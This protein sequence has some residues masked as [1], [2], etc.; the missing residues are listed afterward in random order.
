MVQF[1]KITL[2]RWRVCDY[3]LEVDVIFMSCRYSE[4]EI[5]YFFPKDTV[6]EKYH[7]KVL[8]GETWV[9]ALCRVLTKEELEAAHT[10]LLELLSRKGPIRCDGS[11]LDMSSA[12]RA[13]RYSAESYYVDVH[14]DPKGRLNDYGEVVRHRYVSAKWQY[15]IIDDALVDAISR[16]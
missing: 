1:G 15:K 2:A 9:D 8:S 4:L 16:K 3:V 14:L 13:L 6:F 7:V 12:L 11:S 10:E 5:N